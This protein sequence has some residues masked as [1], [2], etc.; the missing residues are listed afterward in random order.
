MAYWSV[1]KSKRTNARDRNLPLA[2]AAWLWLAIAG[3]SLLGYPNESNFSPGTFS[4]LGN[5]K[6]LAL[7]CAFGLPAVPVA[8]I[9]TTALF[10]RR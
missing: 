7:W 8:A 4:G 3:L 2:V 6:F 9:T 5:V 1:D 10:R